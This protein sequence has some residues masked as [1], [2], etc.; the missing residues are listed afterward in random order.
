MY[1]GSSNAETMIC[2]ACHRPKPADTFRHCADCRARAKAGKDLRAIGI[3]VRG[4]QE[5]AYHRIDKPG[6]ACLNCTLPLGCV[7]DQFSPYE[8][9]QCP[10]GRK[11]P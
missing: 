8:K 2:P 1:R 9:S 7:Y 10:L 3:W 11:T 4:Q 6:L 5:P